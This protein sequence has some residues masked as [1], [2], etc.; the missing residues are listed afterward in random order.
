M[1]RFILGLGLLAAAVQ[2]GCSNVPS[3]PR[4][5]GARQSLDRNA[6]PEQLVALANDNARRI[7]A[8][9][10][11]DVVLEVRGNGQSGVI[12]G[13]MDAMKS[14]N[15]RL[16]GKAGGQP[17][18]DLGS[19]DNEFWYW[20]SK[21]DPPYVYHCTHDALARGNV[22]MHIPFQPEM[23]LTAL[24]MGEYD[25]T[26]KYDVKSNASTIEMT[27]TTTSPQGQTIQKITV[28]NRG[29][30]KANQPLIAAH[31]LLDGQGKK[32]CSATI[33]EATRDASGAELPRRVV[34]NWP[35]QKIELRMKLENVRVVEADPQ[36]ARTLFNRANLN[37]QKSYDLATGR[38][39][40]PTGFVQ[41]ASSPP[42]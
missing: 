12:Y 34:L 31:H 9:R 3:R 38:E 14:R 22:R 11:D 16:T 32:I 28:F 36:L 21:A 17:L 13:R 27:E 41:R 8:L 18:V 1:R 10:C 29:S 30:L 4:V 35:D 7:P 19:N 39:D 15:F 25:S 20:I 37:S 24:G 33:A 5:D 40:I 23:V 26:K 2:V 42:R 6:T